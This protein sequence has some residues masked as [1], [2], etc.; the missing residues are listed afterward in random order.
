MLATGSL[1]SSSSAML[2]DE[3]Q[4]F[5][6][7]QSLRFAVV[8]KTERCYL[9]TTVLMITS[10]FAFWIAA[11]DAIHVGATEEDIGLTDAFGTQCL[12]L[13]LGNFVYAM[14]PDVIRTNQEK[15][16][17]PSDAE[18]Q[19]RAGITCWFGAAPV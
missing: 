16:S 14:R 4:G 12:E 1:R 15:L 2:N 17:A 3:R 6:R 8:R 13:I 10:G 5:A 19:L 9:P 18:H 11:T 7:A